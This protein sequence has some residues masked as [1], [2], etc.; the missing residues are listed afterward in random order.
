M[1][2]AAL[3]KEVADWAEAAQTRDAPVRFDMTD[4]ISSH[5]LEDAFDEDAGVDVPVPVE[6]LREG[7][8]GT[9][10]CVAGYVVMMRAPKGTTTTGSTLYLPD[11]V[12][13]DC[14]AFAQE[15]LDL[16][17]EVASAIFYTGNESAIARLRYL[18]EHPD[19]TQYEL[20]RIGY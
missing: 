11:D 3:C 2:N 8:C 12:I 17:R 1:T 6:K 18:A 15:E 20:E 4:W 14:A 19:A 13:T 7:S 10:A 5:V 9:S 16:T